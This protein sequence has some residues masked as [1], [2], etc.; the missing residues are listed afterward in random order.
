MYFHLPGNAHFIYIFL[1]MLFGNSDERCAVFTD[2]SLFSY[3]MHSS[4][5]FE[6]FF[7]HGPTVHF[8]ILIPGMSFTSGN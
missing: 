3:L 7:C 5:P 4:Y 8:Q 2:A 6:T 1:F